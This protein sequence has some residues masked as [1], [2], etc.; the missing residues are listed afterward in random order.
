MAFNIYVKLD[1]PEALRRGHPFN[2]SPAG[3]VWI[4]VGLANPLG[5][6]VPVQK[7]ASRIGSMAPLNSNSVVARAGEVRES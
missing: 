3:G 2:L 7:C 5:L 1:V 6:C 4:S